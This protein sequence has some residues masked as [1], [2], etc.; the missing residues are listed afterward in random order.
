M[1][2]LHHK[3]AREDKACIAEQAPLAGPELIRPE[4]ELGTYILPSWEYVE[5]G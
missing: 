4:K 3:D 2:V 1:K 5:A